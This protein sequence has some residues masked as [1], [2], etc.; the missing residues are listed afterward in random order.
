[1]RDFSYIILD[2]KGICAKLLWE[3]V[4]NLQVKRSTFSRQGRKVSINP[5]F[6]EKA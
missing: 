1:M 4:P 6:F 5:F 3:I 2:L